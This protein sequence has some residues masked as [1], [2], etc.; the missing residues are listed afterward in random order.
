M[1]ASLPSPGKPFASNRFLQIL[2]ALYALVWL[3]AAIGPRDFPTWALENLLVVLF[4]ALLA[5]TYRRFAFSNTSYLLLGIF[6]CF[7]AYG[8]HYGYAHTP[9]GDWLKSSFALQRNPYDR[10]I[11][12][13]FGFLL[14][15]PLREILLRIARIRPGATLWLAPSMILA[16]STF[17]EVVEAIVAELVSP[18]AGPEWLGGQGDPWDS[19]SDMTVAT[20]GALATMAVAWLVE[21]RPPSAPQPA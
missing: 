2:S 12:C 10:I 3:V 9:F 7:H 5:A 8:A 6:L 1:P 20:L 16:A 14:V 21:R 11:H 15:Y 4:V 13:A 17:F 18:G 19:Q